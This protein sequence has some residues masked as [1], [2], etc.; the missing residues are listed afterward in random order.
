MVLL[1]LSAAFDTIDHGILLS[2]LRSIGVKGAA[3]DWIKS[4][5]SDRTQAVSINGTLSSNVHLPFGVPQGSVL[6]PI[7]FT[8]YS[9]P[10]IAIAQKHGLNVHSYA[11]DTQLYLS[12]NLDDPNAEHSTRQCIE[13][14]VS[15]IKS[16]MTTNK[17]KLNDEKTDLLVVTS[18][19]NQTKIQT[20]QM[21]IG[22]S[23]IQPSIAARNLGIIFD[24]TLSMESHVKKL[25]QTAFFHIRNINSIR[26]CLPDDS[27]AL[28]VHALITSRLDNCNSLL[29]GI[30]DKLVRKIQCVQ[31]AAA[32]ILTKTRKHD[33]ITPIL[34]HLHWLP[35]RHRIDYKIILL[36]WKALNGKAPVYLEELLIRYSSGRTLRSAGKNLL[37]IPRTST[38]AGDKAFSVAA[39]KLWNSL[40][41]NIRCCNSLLTFKNNLKTHLFTI[42]YN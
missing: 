41:L 32:R 37:A 30:P 2:R 42:A 16:W 23:I 12:F 26:R 13:K 24:N 15:D 10:V 6:G 19:N 5:I 39:P 17:L 3:L 22:N 34:K 8:I 27:A 28:I 35:V 38:A 40:P 1:D 25:C 29:Y 20:K 9:R 21:Q 11:D 4:Y 31:N 18:R 7:L 33:H 36:T 14:C